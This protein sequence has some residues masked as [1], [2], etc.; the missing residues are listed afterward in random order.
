MDPDE[1]DYLEKR[2]LSSPYN[3]SRQRSGSSD[4]PKPSQPRLPENYQYHSQLTGEGLFGIS[5]YGLIILCFLIFA[6]LMLFGL[7]HA[8]LPRDTMHIQ[9]RTFIISGGAAG[10]GFATAQDLHERG[11][12]IA[13]LDMNAKNGEAAIKALGGDARARFYECDITQTASIES[14]LSSI[15]TWMQSTQAPIG[16][17]IPAAGVGFPGKLID[18]SNNPIPM[19]NLDFVLNINLRGVLDLV[20]LTLPLM[21]TSKPL[22]PDN[23]RGVIILVSSS[24]AFDGQPGQAAY[25]ASKGA[26]RSLTLVLARDLASL[27]IRCMSIAPSFFDSNMTRMMSDKVRKSLEGVFEFPKRPGQG[28]EFAMMVRSCVENTMLNGECVRLDGATRMPS[29]M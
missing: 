27:G 4:N 1:L 9:D 25:A 14:A 26:I 17:L 12:Y 5:A 21:S 10:L 29:K 2:G 28:K 15:S 24:A 19:E 3:A 8:P 23:E 16:A 22:P 7:V 13:I 18:K 20:R 6:G 11:G